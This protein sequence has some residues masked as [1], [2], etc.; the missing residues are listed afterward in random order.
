MPYMEAAGRVLLGIVFMIAFLG[1]VRS[2]EAFQAFADSL[3]NL[4]WLTERARTYVAV[5]IPVSEIAVAIMLSLP[6]TALWGL[7]AGLSLL[8]ALTIGAGAAIAHGRPVECRCFGAT[9]RPIG[10]SGLIRNGFLIVVALAGL[11]ARMTAQHGPVNW[12][13]MTLAVGVAFL[14]A[15]LVTGW[16]EIAYLITT[17]SV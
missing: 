9:A 14:G 12:T 1:K 4:G 10:R 16:D 15:L 7:A 3:R 6:A 8:S 17:K 5:A 11:V 2:R 13:G